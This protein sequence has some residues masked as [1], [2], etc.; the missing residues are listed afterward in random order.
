M[1]RK[2]IIC[3]LCAHSVQ[4]AADYLERKI[5][6]YSENISVE[7]F[8]DISVFAARAADLAEDGNIV[9]AAAPLGMFLNAKLRFLKSL[10]L[11]AV[12]SSS[13]LAAM[14]TNAPLN[15]KECDLQAAVP[16][17][18]KV[19]LSQDGLYSAFAADDDGSTVVFVPLDE[20]R[21]SYLFTSGLEG[22]FSGSENDS[23]ASPY[24]APAQ[25]KTKK[26]ELNERVSAVI[27]SGKTVAVSS[28]GSGK[29]LL[30]AISSVPD[31]EKAFVADSAIGEREENESATDYI[32]R[33][34]KISKEN[35]GTDL[36]IAIS[37]VYNDNEA[38]GDF[39]I[40]CVADSDRAK[41]TKVYAN[42]GEDKKLLIVAAIIKLCQ[43]L[44]ELT[45]TGLVNPAVA[46]TAK[47]WKK[48]SKTPLIITI[49]GIVIAIIACIVAAFV[50]SGQED[51]TSMTFAEQN[52]Y[53]QQENT[54]PSEN[55]YYNDYQG[56][57]YLGMS[58]TISPDFEPVVTTSTTFGFLT[59]TKRLTTTTAR[60][61]VKQTVTKL[62]T[63]VVSTT[64]LIT[65]T[66][67]PTT[68]TTT[69]PTTTT[70]TTTTTTST[71]A[72]STALTSD[73]STTVPPSTDTSSTSGTTGTGS[74][75]GGGK[76]IFRV[77]GYGHGVGM[78]Q[79]GAIQMAKDGKTY[80]QILTNYFIGTTVK[81]DSAAPLK[82]KYGDKEIPIVEYL[83]KTTYK[84][85]GPSAPMEALKAQ[86]VS[87]YTFAK[88]YNFDVKKSLHAYKEDFNYPGSN[89]YKACLDV[90]GLTDEFGAPQ[91]KYIDYNGKPAFTCYFASSPGKTASSNSVWGG[92]QYPYLVGGASS[93]EKV[94]ASTKEISVDEM[95]K[96][97]QSYAKDNGYEI[98][99]GEDPATW[100]QIVSHDSAYEENIGYVTKI[101]IGDKW[102]RK[103]DGKEMVNQMRGNTFR[104]NL[105]DF[106]IK[107]HCFIFE[108]IPA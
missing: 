39:V 59:T 10:S 106:A 76:F 30:S 81:T 88:Y 95:R 67:K 5:G 35:S 60:T 64:K 66:L 63:T 104:C 75:N 12:K 29:H 107:S 92:D 108:Y 96:Y 16:H 73:A 72:S 87:A 57:S 11:K 22:I 41:A 44:D 8:G 52:G 78:S 19:F 25:P 14:G 36:G 77:Y 23:A 31:C 43:M 18:S 13:I 37:G 58:D 17:K 6:V 20:G 55:N 34:A 40:V 99:L 7:D 70:T 93:P 100:L 24:I 49:I 51:D 38:D 50:L 94:D 21:L 53:I 71:T 97:I 28:C 1:N 27:S 32:A 98:T 91:A 42:P 2:V 47:K 68:T 56:G 4:G 103:S 85:I 86:V 65:T 79:E 82:V 84:E 61:T 48:N 105:L 62:V 3:T 15:V 26:Q 80:D 102:I 33:C 46:A 9:V 89:I 101:R 54:L 45:V 69:R 90:L 83:C 74:G